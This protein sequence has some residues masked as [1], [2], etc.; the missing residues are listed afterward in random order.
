MGLSSL[1]AKAQEKVN[2]ISFRKEKE[3]QEEK[4]RQKEK[5]NGWIDSQ[6]EKA[7]AC[8]ESCNS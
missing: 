8:S 5:V 6:A 7:S 4:E 2:A 3:R 1:D